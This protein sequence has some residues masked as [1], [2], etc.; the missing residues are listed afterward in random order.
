MD[1]LATAQPLPDGRR[2]PGGHPAVQVPGEEHL[3][4]EG[5]MRGGGATV[6]VP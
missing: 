1:S 5:Y 6:Q 3:H 4:L 2:L